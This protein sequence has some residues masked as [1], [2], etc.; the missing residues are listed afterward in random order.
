LNQPLLEKDYR[1]NGIEFDFREQYYLKILEDE[2]RMCHKG[3][4]YKGYL[5]PPVDFLT[6]IQTTLPR[7][8]GDDNIQKFTTERDYRYGDMIQTEALTRH[9]PS[10]LLARSI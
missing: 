8:F 9:D 2:T 3:V 10:I 5:L 6:G 7:F 1:K 4:A